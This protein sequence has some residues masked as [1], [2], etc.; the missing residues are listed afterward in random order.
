MDWRWLWLL[1]PVFLLLQYFVRVDFWLWIPV[2]GLLAVLYS[3]WALGCEDGGLSRGVATAAVYG[4][5]LVAVGWVFG[6]EASVYGGSPAASVLNAVF[7]GVLALARELARSAALSAVGSGDLRVFLV[8]ATL[9]FEPGWL[10]PSPTWV[11]TVLVPSLA[12]S[13][14]ASYLQLRYG[15][16]ASLPLAFVW[17][18]APYVAP[19]WVKAPWVF[20]G[21]L[22]I[23]FLIGVLLDVSPPGS[24]AW[25]DVLLAGVVVLVVVFA[26][27]GLG[28]RPFVV[29]T[30]SMSPVYM[31]GDVV[32]VAPAKSINVG[33]VVL[34]RADV[35]YVL[36][37]VID[38]RREGRQIYYVTKGDA[39]ASPDPRP[40]PR[41]NVVGVAV[42]RIPY[43]GWPALWIRDPAGG[44]PYLAALLGG[45]AGVELALGRVIRRRNG[46]S[47]SR[48]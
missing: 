22:H 5:L 3:R 10:R 44:W 19:V 25:R 36:H 33:D 42:G 16:F 7:F 32:L 26:A 34:Y 45:V 31:P 30:G 35:G 39:N 8:S 11:G 2:W 15:T 37:R 20:Y 18:V 24:V 48:R 47:S 28:V 21:L 1:L 29:A 46:L 6:W 9:A 14:A 12:V 43:V 40:V 38:V 41:E 23:L 17:G 4:A 27:G 13:L